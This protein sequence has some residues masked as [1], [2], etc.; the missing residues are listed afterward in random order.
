MFFRIPK[1]GLVYTVR[2]V[3]FREFR[4]KRFG[5]GGRIDVF[6]HGFGN[7]PMVAM[8]A[9]KTG[10]G[11]IG[12]VRRH[13]HIRLYSSYDFYYFGAQGLGVFNFSVN[14]IQKQNFFYSYDFGRV[15]LLFYAQG[16]HGFGSESS[17]VRAFA[18]ISN[19]T[20]NNFIASLS[21]PSG[22]SGKTEVHV[23]RMRRENKHFLKK[24][25]TPEL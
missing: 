11:F 1:P 20:I 22:A 17:F 10:K 16:F 18:A 6:K 14:F 7:L 19:N 2:P 13:N 24:H 23:V 3:F 9:V 8:E 25:Q 12:R 15:Y 4:K 5:A 21:Q